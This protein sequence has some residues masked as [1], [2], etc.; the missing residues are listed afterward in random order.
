MSANLP[1]YRLKIERA[2]RHIQELAAE[3][4]AF[5]SRSPY[6]VVKNLDSQTGDIVFKLKII[7]GIPRT[8]GPIIGDVI[9]NIRSSLD[10]LFC[11]VVRKC[12]PTRQSYKHVHFVVRET[13][14][15]FEADLPANIKG[16]SPD[17][18]KLI[19]DLK[20]YKAGNDPLWRL[21]GLDILDKHQAIIPVWS[22]YEAFNMG[23]AMSARMTELWNSASDGRPKRANFPVLDFWLRPADRSP[24]YDGSELLRIMPAAQSN[25]DDKHQ[26]RIEIAFGQSEIVDGEPIVP[27]LTQLAD[28]VAGVFEPFETAILR[29]PPLAMASL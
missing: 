4:S 25:H 17:A 21:H 2:K 12:D 14:E 6:A 1:D 5:N 18:I 11:A 20:P 9:H 10:L 29:C 23:H 3:V 13:K 28:Y 15:K 24:L 7:E 27:A 19:H 26:F 16:A 22:R 8:W